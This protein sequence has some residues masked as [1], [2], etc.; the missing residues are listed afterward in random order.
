[1]DET[2]TTYDYR[3][4]IQSLKNISSLLKSSEFHERVGSFLKLGGS[5]KTIPPSA[6]VLDRTLSRSSFAPLGKLDTDV[7]K[8][9]VTLKKTILS[10]QPEG[11]SPASYR[12]FLLASQLES[13]LTSGERG[14]LN[15]LFCNDAWQNLELTSTASYS[16][17]QS[18]FK[19]L[20]T[21]NI[22]SRS[23][24]ECESYVQQ[25]MA[26]SD[27]KTSAATRPTKYEDLAFQKIPKSV[28][29]VCNKQKSG[30]RPISSESQKRILL[31]AHRDLRGLYD[32]H[33]SA[34]IELL[35][36]VLF[37]GSG[38][39]Y[40]SLPRIQ[41]DSELRR[42]PRGSQ[43]ALDEKIAEAR[44]LIARHYIQVETVYKRALDK[45]GAIA[46]GERVETP[47]NTILIDYN[48][49]PRSGSESES[50]LGGN[51]FST[52]ASPDT[53]NNADRLETVSKNLR[54]NVRS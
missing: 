5:V 11:Y 38:A 48:S 8:R 50:G 36:R 44:A 37:F 54:S 2:G 7:Y 45:L 35:R 13:D 3:E 47:S 20:T 18:L 17:L 43:Y 22:S 4:Y 23:A 52:S 39:S 26:V 29:S 41:L 49:T 16:L 34:C 21:G 15:S 30:P 10:G 51:E 32:E 1:M 9:L 19:D 6:Q 12:A 40:M 31:D 27:A 46:T 33:L 24:S 42:H 28:E 53:R 14:T 25:Q